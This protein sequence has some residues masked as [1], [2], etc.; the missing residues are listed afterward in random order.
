MVNHF[1]SLLSNINLR[2]IES[3]EQKYELVFGGNS[4]ISAGGGT[5]SFGNYTAVAENRLLLPLVD[6]NYAF[7]TLPKELQRVYDILFPAT[8]TTHYKQ[9]LLYTYLRIVDLTEYADEIKTVDRRISYSLD[10]LVDYFKFRNISIVS[11]NDSNYGILVYGAGR[12][13]ETSRGFTSLYTVSQQSNTATVLIQSNTQGLYYHPTKTSSASSIGMTVTVTPSSTDPLVSAPIPIG[14]TGLAC[15]LGGKNPITATSNKV[16]RFSVDSPV[17]FNI[18]DKI[19]TLAAYGPT[20]EAMFNYQRASC[21]QSYQNLWE[22]HHSPVYRL[23]GLLLAYVERVN[24]VWQK[25]A[26]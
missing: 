25:R 16:W 21:N 5:L 12:S 6:R 2:A 11:S 4:T 22:K 18:L 10:E 14:D 24:L 1:A 17:N 13:D 26:T 20:I 8:I 15:V 23:A 19:K 3:V 7:L 9:F